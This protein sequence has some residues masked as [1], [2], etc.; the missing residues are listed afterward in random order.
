VFGLLAGFHRGSAPAPINLLAALWVCGD[1][2]GPVRRVDN[3]V[4]FFHIRI[5]NNG[6]RDAREAI[7]PGLLADL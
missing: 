1:K 3:D 7:H 4:G 2:D 6:R 5:N